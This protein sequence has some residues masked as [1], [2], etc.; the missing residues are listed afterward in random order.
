VR[1]CPAKA[2]RIQE[3]QAE[4]LATRCIA[5]G[6]CVRVCSQG[7]KRVVSTFSDV[8]KLLDDPARRVAACLAPSFPAE[9]VDYE[10]PRLV[11]ALRALGFSLVTEVAFGADLV[12]E[13]Y[14]EMMSG[15]ESRRFIATTCPAVVSF[16]EKQ[17]PELVPNLMP[18]VSPMTATA[19]ALRH[20]YGE[21]VA[22]VFIG[23]C[24]GKKK[25]A[26]AGNDV[27]EA[28]TFRELREL[29]ERRGVDPR[30]S[31][32]SSFNAP[33]PNLGALF[34]L[35]RGMLQAAGLM[36]D[37]TTNDVVAAEGRSEFVETIR[38]FASGSLNARLLEVLC[39]PGCIMGVGMTTSA[40]QFRRRASVGAYVRETVTRYD[41]RRWHEDMRQLGSLDLSRTFTTDDQRLP[42]PPERELRSV[43]ER[44]GKR[45][46]ADELDCGACGYDTCRDHAIAIWRGLAESE[47]CLPWTIDT[48][49]HA[50]GKLADSHKLLASTQEALMQSEKLASMGQLAAGIAH[51][52]N[53]PLGVVLMYSHL[54]QEEVPEDSELRHDLALLSEQAERCRRIV[55]GLLDFARQNRVLYQDVD[56]RALMDK[57]LR[58]VPLP[59]GVEVVREYGEQHAVAELDPDQMV[60]VLTNLITN[61]YAAMAG[62]GIL[63]ARVLGTS[64][65]VCFEVADTGCGIPEDHRT[66]IFEPFF[67]TKNMGEGTG[68][69]LSVAYGIIKMH[70]GQI[71]LVSQA[72]PDKGPTGSTFTVR[73]PRRGRLE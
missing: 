5:C 16:V 36:E 43:L 63:T 47:M 39:C 50:V 13:R 10:L 9:F 49:H 31:E 69:G 56:V 66:K 37:L 23:P 30:S 42:I 65:Q 53:N 6:N 3:G 34:S 61:A 21:N 7:A 12:A 46:P 18:I 45:E 20:E 68:L 29:F 48:L 55:S 35:S 11:G 2:I 17:Y 64:D 54:L 52:V 24:V 44:I 4:L 14:V 19:R 40:P 28:I 57:A 51:E 27:D 26:E 41:K 67:T 33:H 1:E 72:D 25:E 71:T 58:S 59:A 15:N 32:P 62:G 60:Q 8:E 70:R 73:L 38:E 22:I